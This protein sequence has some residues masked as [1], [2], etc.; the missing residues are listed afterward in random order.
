MID[1]SP[2]LD[3]HVHH[4]IRAHL[5]AASLMTSYLPVAASTGLGRFLLRRRHHG[6]VA[7]HL[8]GVLRL[9]G[10]RLAPDNTSVN[11]SQRNSYVLI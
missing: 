9:A 3:T 8:L 5:T 2:I 4:H 6:E 11:T 10:A 7:D 1:L